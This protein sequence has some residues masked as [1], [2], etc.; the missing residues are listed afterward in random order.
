MLCSGDALG[1]SPC[2]G[3]EENHWCRK[4]LLEV[5][6]DLKRA[7]HLARRCIHVRC[8]ASQNKSGQGVEKWVAGVVTAATCRG[9]VRVNQGRWL[10]EGGW[11]RREKKVGCG[12]R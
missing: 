3:C 1:N 6:E 4:L 12:E 11:A 9:L 8:F 10:V 5:V 2:D 7:S